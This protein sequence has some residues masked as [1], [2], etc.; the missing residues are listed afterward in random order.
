MVEWIFAF[1]ATR[2]FSTINFTT[3]RTAC[4]DF[5]DHKATSVELWVAKT[6]SEFNSHLN[7]FTPHGLIRKH[8]IDDEYSLRVCT[9]FFGVEFDCFNQQMQTFSPD[10]FQ[11][12]RP[13]EKLFRSAEKIEWTTCSFLERFS[14]DGPKKHLNRCS[15][16]RFY[17]AFWNR[18]LRKS[19]SRFC[20][21]F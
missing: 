21:A 15:N 5:T 6:P 4:P 18:I 19:W 17:G 7:T 13:A 10:F 12:I 14:S 3:L 8:K 1:P 2:T 16:F 9:V 20:T 11:P